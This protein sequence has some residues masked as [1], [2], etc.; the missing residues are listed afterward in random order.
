[1]YP[2]FLTLPSPYCGF[3]LARPPS[4]FPISYFWFLH[5]SSILHFL[6]LPFPVSS[7]TTFPPAPSLLPNPNFSFL[8]FSNNFIF[9]F[10]PPF[11]VLSLF[12]LLLSF[13]LLPFLPYHTPAS[14][15]DSFFP[16]TFPFLLSLFLPLPTLLLPPFPSFFSSTFPFSSPFPKLPH[17]CFLFSSAPSHPFL[18]S[19]HFLVPD[20]S[21][22]S[23]LPR[24][25]LRPS[26]HFPALLPQGPRRRV[27]EA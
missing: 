19:S 7:F 8:I 23:A 13:P 17:F 1:M 10:P 2:L 22:S 21:F 18:L 26:S 12:L 16:P 25:L 6:S 5:L 24:L 11:P 9:S 14:A 20:S 15:T 27:S 3:F 4:P